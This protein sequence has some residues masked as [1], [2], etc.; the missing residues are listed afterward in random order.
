MIR[1]NFPVSSSFLRPCITVSLEFV[2][3]TPSITFALMAALS[4]HFVSCS[5]LSVPTHSSPCY[6]ED[7]RSWLY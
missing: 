4:F 5:S 6:S 2:L 1:T 3:P 7:E